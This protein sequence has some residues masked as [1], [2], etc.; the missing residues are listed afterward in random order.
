LSIE[1]KKSSREFVLPIAKD[2]SLVLVNE[3]RLNPLVL[4][5]IPVPLLVIRQICLI[6]ILLSDKAKWG[7]NSVS[8]IHQWSITFRC[9]SSEHHTDIS[10]V[11]KD[12]YLEVVVSSN[13]FGFSW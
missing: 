6:I 11:K 9:D 3:R 13:S 4:S 5:Q 10:R 12:S 8:Y 1:S 7:R 2:S